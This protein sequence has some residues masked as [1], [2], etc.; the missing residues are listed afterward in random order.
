[1]PIGRRRSRPSAPLLL[2]A[3]ALSWALPQ[4]AAAETSSDLGAA[5]D[6]AQAD[7]D[8]GRPERA[9]DVLEP[10]LQTNAD[11]LILRF[12]IG[13]CL[14]GIGEPRAAIAQYRFILA[15]DP[16]A[17]RAR[18]ELAVAELSAGDTNA[19]KA[20]FEAVLAS[21]PPPEIRA[22]LQGMLD[23][24]PPRPQ[25][26]ASASAA[27]M[28]DSNADLG[29][30]NN[31]ITLFGAPYRLI[32][33]PPRAKGD[34]AVLGTADLGMS[35]PANATW[36]WQADLAANDV[37]YASLDKFDFDSYSFSAG[38]ALH[39]D[40]FGMAANFGANF[41]RLGDAPYSFSWGAEPDFTFRLSEWL[42]LEQQFSVQG[43]HYYTTR[44]TDGWSGVSTSALKWN[45]A[46]T[47]AYLEPKLALT[48][49]EA[50]NA[51]Y[52]D[53]QVGGEVDFFQP[54][55]SGCSILLEPA[56]SEADYRAADPAFGNARHDETYMLSANFGYEP[57]FLDSQIALGVTA[58]ANRSNQALYSY[59]RVQTTLQFKMPL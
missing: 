10:F 54:L 8:A 17:V 9:C 37:T 29:P 20:D 50:R 47:D 12:L 36:S 7:L 38:P 19:A 52:T 59:D 55:G 2:A 51:I 27:V 22:K 26:S 42:T 49:Q 6:S 58:T 3:L 48:H 28:Y 45:F 23:G 18:A 33:A 35:Y 24:I 11:D 43:N 5:K 34:W 14:A 56:I 39:T 21:G 41:A 13:Q 32:N 44:A 16:G 46:G 15:H 40:R 31:I 57:G 4:S 30:L 25:W 53:D 1:M